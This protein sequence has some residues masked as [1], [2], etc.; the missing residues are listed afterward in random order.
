MKQYTKLPI[1]IDTAWDDTRF[2]WGKYVHWRIRYFF[3]GVWN[4]IRWMPTIYHDKDWD[5]YYITKLLQKKL[6]FHRAHLVYANRHVNI[7]RDNF[8]MTIV[9]N[10]IERKHS[11][12]YDLERYKYIVI[13]DEDILGEPLSETLDE[14]IAKYPGAKRAALKKYKDHSHLEDKETISLYMGHLRQQK[15]DDLIFEILKRHSAEW[16]D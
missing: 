16:W 9:L 14:Y 6:E 15:A 7:D 12:Y 8:W 10:L 4:I 11:D 1:P 13:N 3:T 2:K 5:D